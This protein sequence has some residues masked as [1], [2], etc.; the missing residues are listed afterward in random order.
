MLYNSKI[1]QLLHYIKL[2]LQRYS[3]LHAIPPRPSENH[4]AMQ[5]VTTGGKLI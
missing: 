1:Y 2:S 3:T 4:I 5:I